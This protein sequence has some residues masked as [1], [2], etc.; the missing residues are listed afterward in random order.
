MPA[1][2]LSES[3]LD[4]LRHMLGVNDL[5]GK[6]PAPYRNYYCACPGDRQ[7]H[8]LQRLGAVEMYQRTTKGA[9]G[10]Y[11]WFK[12]TDAGAAAALRSCPK[13]LTGAKKRYRAFLDARD[14][15]DDLTFREFLTHD[16]FR[17]HRR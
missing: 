9:G 7:L 6:S 15:Y 13:P 1:I 10:D 5:N 8:E 14:A 16:H 11:E 17:E 4:I 2:N 3:Q 12:C